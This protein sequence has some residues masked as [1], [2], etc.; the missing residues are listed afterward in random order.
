M[1]NVGRLVV[2]LSL[3]YLALGLV[4]LALYLLGVPL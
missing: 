3:F 1:G 2:C 4:Q